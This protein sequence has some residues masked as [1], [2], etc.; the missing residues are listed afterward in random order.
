MSDH[1][2]DPNYNAKSVG[3]LIGR[4]FRLLRTNLRLLIGIT[5]APP[6]VL[7]F[8]LGSLFSVVMLPHLA[9]MPKTPDPAWES[10]T[11]ASFIS[12]ALG[13]YFLFL[14][15]LA[16]ALAAASKAAVLADFGAHIRFRE[17]CAGALEKFSRYVLL[18]ALIGIITSGPFFVLQLVMFGIA[19]L[20]PHRF[21]TPT[22]SS[23]AILTLGIG[24]AFA[25][26]VY[27][28][29]ATLRLSLAFPACVT[30]NLPATAS[31]KR[32]SQLTRGAT[33]KI[34]LVLL[35]VYAIAYV[36]YVV[37]LFATFSLFSLPILAASLLHVHLARAAS[38]LLFVCIVGAMLLVMIFGMALSIGACTTALAVIYN[39]QRM[40]IDG[41]PT[42]PE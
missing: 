28:I 33:G 20:L 32:S 26:F 12:I 30:E 37:G 6:A 7:L 2:E 42:T 10:R 9:T 41:I 40:R 16:P 18:L 35:T 25:S 8:A 31:I 13:A 38:V 11:G 1:P 21:D 22:P 19:V 3:Q 23:I 17:A 4:T 24:S 5:A 15:A 36:V 14:V 27:S 39:D 29:L 34:F